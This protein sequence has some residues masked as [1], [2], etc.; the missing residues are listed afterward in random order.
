M[1]VAA[2]LDVDAK[3]KAPVRFGDSIRVVM[4]LTQRRP[5]LSR[6]GSHI[7]TFEDRVLRQDGMVVA[8]ITRHILISETDSP[9]E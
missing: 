1:R 7:L 5:S 6:P 8:H 9:H 2:A 3:F 4:T